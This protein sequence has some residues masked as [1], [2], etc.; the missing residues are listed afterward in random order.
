MASKEV[1]DRL[2]GFLAHVSITLGQTQGKTCLPLP[3]DDAFSSNIST[4]DRIHLLEGAV[5]TWTKQIKNVLKQDPEGLLKAGLHPTP[6]KEVEF[7]KDKASNL[8]AIFE[9]LQSERIRRVLQFLDQAKSTYCTPFA[10]LCKEVFTARLEANDN[11]KYLRTLEGWFDRLNN[12][13]EFPAL[14]ELFKPMLHILLLIWKNSKYYNTPARLVVLIREICNALIEQACQYVSGRQVFELIANEEATEAVSKLKTTLDVC[15]AFKATYFDYKST[16]NAECPKNPWRI[17][18]NAL[19]MRLDAFME[20]CHDILHLTETIMQFSRLSKIEIGGT[21]G[22][23]LTNS[24]KQIHTDFERAVDLFKAVPYD[25]MDVGKKEFDDDFYDFR[26]RIKELERRLGS[27]LTQGFDDCATIYGRFK[28]LDSFEGLLERPI[29]QD[30]LERKH[31]ALVQAY[32]QDLKAVQELFLT[33]RDNPPIARN[34]PPIAGAL[35]WCRGLK[36]RIQEPMSKLETLNKSIMEREEAKEV[37]KVYSTIISSLED[38]E[39]QKIEE[40]G[41]DV[42]RSSAAK[43]KLPLLTRVAD[44]S[45]RPLLRVNFDPALV[46]LLREVKYFLLLKLEVP[47]SALEIYNKG[48]TYRQQTGNLEIIVHMYNRIMT[49]LL[50]VE[51]PL[52]RAQLGKIDEM[53]QAGIKDLNWRSGAAIDEFITNTQAVVKDAHD[54]LFELKDN[55]GGVQENLDVW[56]KEPMLVRKSKPVA[57]EELSS[58]FKMQKKSKFDAIKKGGKE[59]ERML[60]ASHAIMKVSKTHPNWKAYVDFV[61]GI[62]VDG[63]AKSIASSLEYLVDNINPDNSAKPML[64]IQLDLTAQVSRFIPDVGPH[65]PEYSGLKGLVQGW[66]DAFYQMS[67]ILRRIDDGEGSYVKEMVDDLNIRRLLALV[68]ARMEE[69]ERLLLEYKGKFDAYSHLWTDDMRSTFNNFLKTAY[70]EY[71]VDEKKTLKLKE[72]VVKEEEENDEAKE[73]GEDDHETVNVKLPNLKKF[74][75]AISHYRHLR[76][77]VD[78]LKSPARVGWVLVDS[79]PMKDALG[80]WLAKY[81]NMYTQYLSNY[82]VDTLKEVEHFMVD[83]DSGLQVTVEEGE[84]GKE[85]LKKCM[86]YIRDVKRREKTHTQQALFGPLHTTISTLKKHGVAVD[87]KIGEPPMPVVEYLDNF[88]HALACHAQQDHVQDGGN[89]A[90]AA[91][92]G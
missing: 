14:R 37:T 36:E 63:L 7:W 9:Q 46:R 49:Q 10:K 48:E 51:A 30:E 83:V 65:V 25:I 26:C 78:Q 45:G 72:E 39:H 70:L 89:P 73:E 21:K 92:G 71:V 17:Q 1:M 74:D 31:I 85:N 8:N 79:D 29:I 86:G 4:K 19:F 2:H 84:A 53:L 34:L 58:L 32:G 42:E 81:A 12:A 69:E 62:V 77:E 41:S 5:I 80:T 44:S 91:A 55:L 60:K 13:D 64:T 23:T 40:W 24:V 52:L 3:P 56:S 75:E 68:H 28:L 61:N 57:P 6:D 50:P 20:R 67:T 16:A 15:G 82:V 43:L 18:N 88:A 87:A 38:Y 54:V 47:T 76:H 35:T 33:E 59:I 66:V 11:V 22:K 90:A 27:I